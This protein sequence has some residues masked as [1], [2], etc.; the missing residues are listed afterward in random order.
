MPCHKDCRDGEE[1]VRELSGVR[2][3][4]ILTVNHEF[5]Q[6]L[7]EDQLRELGCVSAESVFVHDHNLSDQSLHNCVQK[8]EQSFAF[9]VE[10]RPDV[11]DDGVV[12][13]GRLR[14]LDLPFE[15]RLLVG[16]ADSG[17]DDFLFRGFLDGFTE[18]ALDVGGVV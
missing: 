1:V 9:E 5:D 2:G 15:V 3:I 13:E 11:F 10:A 6:S 16:A 14:V 17:V 4:F 12:R 7:C 8:G 18:E